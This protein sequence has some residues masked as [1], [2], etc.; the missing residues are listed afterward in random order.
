MR[1]IAGKYRGRVLKSPIGKRIRPTTDRTKEAVFS[2]LE[3]SGGIN[4]KKV[5]DA[6]C[7]SGALGIE[8]L[9]RGAKKVFFMDI[10]TRLV[11]DNVS[12]Y[13]NDNDINVITCDVLSPASSREVMD[14]IFI[15]PPYAMEAGAKSIKILSEKGW[16]N[17]DTLFVVETDKDDE[18][19]LEEDYSYF[20]KKKYGK[21]S[22]YF[23][24]L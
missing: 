10:D 1:V 15:D 5:L 16:A 12:S 3:S 18:C 21:S 23:V 20:K 2:S 22:I 19:M 13:K 17:E 7:G 9:S 11:R 4:N 6:F 8:S 14:I 24:K